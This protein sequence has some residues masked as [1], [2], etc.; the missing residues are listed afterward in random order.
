MCSVQVQPGQSVCTLLTG[1]KPMSDERR[2]PGVPEDDERE[3]RPDRPEDVELPGEDRSEDLPDEFIDLPQPLDDE[4]S[5]SGLGGTSD[6]EASRNR[7]EGLKKDGQDGPADT[8]GYASASVPAVRI[9]GLLDPVTHGVGVNLIDAVQ[10][11]VPGGVPVT[12]GWRGGE[13]RTG[14]EHCVD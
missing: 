1:G 4:D 9:A 7:R 13:L 10:F 12:K 5:E 2:V 6:P 11:D 3:R 14:Q 8:S